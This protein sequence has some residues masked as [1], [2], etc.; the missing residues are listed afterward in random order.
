M[1]ITINLQETLQD[2]RGQQVSYDLL[3]SLPIWGNEMSIC[4]YNKIENFVDNCANIATVH[5]SIPAVISDIALKNSRSFSATLYK[6]V[7]NDELEIHKAISKIADYQKSAKYNDASYWI[8]NK[9]M[10]LHAENRISV[11][12]LL[13]RA[14]DADKYNVRILLSL[15]IA[16]YPFR[17]RLNYR[18]EFYSKVQSL[19]CMQ[20]SKEETQQ[21]L[22]NLGR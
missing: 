3:D 8:Y 16:T 19:I 2:T 13:L 6:S 7:I 11:C 10:D 17:N 5:T 21:I 12:D 9:F 4:K 15:L 20:Y 14:I 1:Y 22:G 18:A